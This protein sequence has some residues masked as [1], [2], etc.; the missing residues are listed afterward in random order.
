MTLATISNDIDKGNYYTAGTRATVNLGIASIGT[1]CAPC[2][3]ALS[4]GEAT[5]GNHCIIMLRKILRKNDS[6]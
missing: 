5:L 1:V 6:I 2:G 4:I 3:F